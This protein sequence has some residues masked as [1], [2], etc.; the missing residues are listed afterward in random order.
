VAH[1]YGIDQISFGGVK[2]DGTG[3]TIAI[4]DTSTAP[5]LNSDLAAFDAA[6]TINAPP[7][8]TVVAPNGTPVYNATW[9]EETT[10]DVEWAHA[11]A[12]GA[13]ILLVQAKSAGINDLLAAVDYARSQAGV[14]VVSMS[15]GT[16]EFNTESSL[17][18]H[19]TTPS[20]HQGVSFIASAGDTGA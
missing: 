14:S 16:G 18:Y 19:F 1:A 20:G 3:Q 11:L 7:N 6:F 15:W 10:L 13:N 17:D 9:A 5:N 12:P 8:L 2:G 4:I